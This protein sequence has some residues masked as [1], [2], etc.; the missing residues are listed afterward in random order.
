[1]VNEGNMAGPLGIN[2]IIV[3]TYHHS[4]GSMPMGIVVSEQ[5]IMGVMWKVRLVLQ[6]ESWP[7]TDGM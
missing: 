3:Q 7:G 4:L 6:V 2:H 1:M 5:V